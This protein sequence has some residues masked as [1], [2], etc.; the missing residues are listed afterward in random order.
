MRLEA[1]DGNGLLPLAAA[2]ADADPVGDCAAADRVFTA[3]AHYRRYVQKA[4]PGHLGAI[5]HAKP[6]VG[7]RLPELPS[8]PKRVTARWQSAPTIADLPIDHAVPVAA[9]RGGSAAATAAL[10]QFVD[11]KLAGYGELNN[12]PEA[13]RTSR[14]S[15][16]LHFGHISSHQIFD[17]VMGREGWSTRRVAGKPA[18]GAREGWWDV[19]ASAER[20][21]DQLVVWRELGYNMCARRPDDYD[22]YESLPQ[23]ALD[24]LKRHARDL[25]PVL[26]DFDTLERGRTSDQVWNAAQGQL[27]REGW[28]H[29]YMRMLWGKKI[30][31]WSKTPREALDRMIAIMNRWALDGRNP[32]SYSGYFWTLGRYDRPWPEREIFGVIRYMSSA[33]TAKKLKVKTYIA[34]YAPDSSPAPALPFDTP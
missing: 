29:S 6:L 17:R 24:S 7:L 28:M 8:L 19:S 27:L 21:L 26:Y 13:D 25:R 33:N 15:P 5:P 22:R 34:T 23:W 18:V 3:A 20:Y 9:M 2:E 32:N 10:K 1:V 31:E 4:L 30:L 12:Q 14:M 11:H 16:Y